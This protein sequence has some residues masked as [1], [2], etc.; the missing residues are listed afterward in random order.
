MKKKF[1]SVLLT[2]VMVLAMMPMATG[3]AFAEGPVEGAGTQASPWLFGATTP[4]D[5]RVWLEE[6]TPQTDPKTYKLYFQ[7]TGEMMNLDQA[8]DLPWLSKDKDKR[9]NILSVEISEG[10]TSIGN[11]ACSGCMNIESIEIP[12]S[13]TNIGKRA[14]SACKN[15]ATVTFLATIPPT[16]GSEVFYNCASLTSIHIPDESGY[17]YDLATGWSTYLPIVKRTNP[18]KIGTPTD[19]AVIAYL[20]KTSETPE[21]YKLVIEGTGDMKGFAS[22]PDQDWLAQRANITEVQIGEGITSIGDYVFANFASL[23]SITIPESI[24]KIGDKAF[25]WSGL[26]EVIFSGNPTVEFIGDASFGC[27]KQLESIVIPE[28]VTEIK[29]EAFGNCGLLEV[30]VLSNIP[31]RL[32]NDDTFIDCDDLISIYV[33]AES[34]GAYKAADGWKA[35]ADNIKAIPGT[36]SAPSYDIEKYREVLAEAE[37]LQ[38][39]IDAKR[40]AETAEKPV[41]TPLTVA[42]AKALVKEMVPVVRTENQARGIKVFLQDSPAINRLKASGF[43]VLYDFYRA[44]SN[45]VPKAEDYKIT[46]VVNKEEPWYLNTAAKKGKKYYYK[47]VAKVYDAN[48]ELVAETELTQGKYGC[49]TR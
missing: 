33:P 31:A 43:K 20:V 11:Y 10:I 37:R 2:L 22:S 3:V 4:S 23:T 25:E 6:V 21:E 34:V 38:A 40:A 19:S 47:A 42:Q 12:A 17:A 15:L 9:N 26:E 44:E 14:F 7:G 48:G 41:G 8:M 1:L 24:K 39:E 5:V 18:W 28:S 27:C 32:Q 35:Y 45:T 36:E 29:D 16:L 46:T 13:V 49:R 30:T